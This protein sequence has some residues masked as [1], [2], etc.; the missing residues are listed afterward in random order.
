MITVPF[1]TNT[2]EKIRVCTHVHEGP[3]STFD[4]IVSSQGR[5]SRGS[6]VSIK[7]LWTKCG[8][9]CC[10]H[11]ACTVN[12]SRQREGGGDRGS[13]WYYQVKSVFT[14]PLSILYQL[15]MST[16]SVICLVIQIKIFLVVGCR[17]SWATFFPSFF[18]AHMA[19][20]IAVYTTRLSNTH[21]SQTGHQSLRVQPLHK[22]TIWRSSNTACMGNTLT[23]QMLHLS[24]YRTH[25]GPRMPSNLSDF[26]LVLPS[27]FLLFFFF[28]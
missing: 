4:L 25:P 13:T 19:A 5:G 11:R 27:L 7:S 22:Q 3:C 12:M 17:P 18:S 16:L 9:A 23:R 14:G 24:M 20:V 2:I 26:F 8:R 1:G 28:H 10:C 15:G 21:T 6:E